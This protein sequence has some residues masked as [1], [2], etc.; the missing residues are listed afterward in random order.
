[1][2]DGFFLKKGKT[3]LSKYIKLFATIFIL[4]LLILIT[5]SFL[6]SPGTEDAEIWQRWMKNVDNYGLI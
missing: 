5:L 3:M 2:G 4:C 1:M 6:H